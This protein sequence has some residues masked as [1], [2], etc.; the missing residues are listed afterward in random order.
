MTYFNTASSKIVLDIFQLVK[1]AKQ[2]GHDVSILWG[3]EEDDEEMCETGEDFAEIIGIDVQ[4]KE[5]PV[6]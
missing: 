3:Y 5:F 6:N 1:N 2:N 4:L